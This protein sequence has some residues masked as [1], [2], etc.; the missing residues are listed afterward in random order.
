MRGIFFLIYAFSIELYRRSLMVSTKTMFLIYAP[1]FNGFRRFNSTARTYAEFLKAKRKIPAYR[2]FLK[3]HGFEKMTYRG[4]MPKL[5]TIPIM[6]K[7]NYVKVYPL[8]ERCIHGKIPTK[9][10][11]ID[12]SSGS[13]GTPTN[14]VRG[15][16]ERKR[17]ARFIQF[18]L[19][20]L[21]GNGP[22]FIINAFALGPWATGMNVSMSC[23]KFSMLK[24]LGPDED[25][26]IN[27][28]KQFGNGHHYVIM[29]YPP[30]LKLLVDKAPI[31]WREYHVT[32]IFG[33]ESMSEGMREYLIKKGI[34]N[35]YSSFGASDLELNISAENDFT[36]SIRRLIWENKAFRER[37]CRFT[38]AVPMVFQ[39]NPSDFLIET[40][41][42]GEL[43]IS[44]T[45][46]HYIS[47]KI[48]YNIH[49]K[50]HM[51]S[52]D[53]V[54]AAMAELGIP[55]DAIQKPRTD[56]P[57][58]FH[59]GRADLTVSFFGSNISPTDIQETI[60]SK[61]DFSEVIHSFQ[62]KMNESKDGD[63]HLCICLEKKVGVNDLP[64]NVQEF[65]S[66]F[67]DQLAIIN[68][69]FKEAKRMISNPSQL[70]I[71]FFSFG[72]GPFETRDMRIKADYFN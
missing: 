1:K 10:V 61:P 7:Q 51:V 65:T 68:Q 48:R 45:R 44:I 72:T 15:K 12:E 18:G 59:Y 49:D 17:N 38:G 30:F 46:P 13:S 20:N 63:K 39:Y 53:E 43:I 37:I 55:A 2:D 35:I 60:F 36:I 6:D 71:E 70:S 66:A 54:N 32:F 23:V 57:L 8:E 42:Q 24:S 11:I 26:I 29:G 3:R 27:T 47:P 19:R 56:L 9:D 22:L 40:S 4:L 25:K 28:L 14:W 21:L 33:G 34:R 41:D 62:I 31:D 67:F 52:L 64:L 58:L 69:D 50:G 5:E 16:I